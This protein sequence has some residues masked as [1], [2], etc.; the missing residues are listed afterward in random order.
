MIDP[1]RKA[2]RIREALF[3]RGRIGVLGC[4]IARLD[5]LAGGLRAILRKRLDLAHVEAALHDL[6][7]DPFR[8]R[9]PDQHAGMAGGNLALRNVSLHGLRQLEQPQRV[10]H[11]AAALAYD[12]GDGVLAMVE[13]CCKRLIAHRLFERIEIGALHILDDRELQ[14]LAIVHIEL[15][16]RHHM[17]AGA[18]RRP[19][20]PL[21]GDD[22]VG[23][24]GAA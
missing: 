8:I 22:L 1:H 9:L 23:I 21:A 17:Q 16:D 10:G 5:R 20:A 13:L 4:A 24:G 12:L 18:L 3:E 15:H 11:V 14:R 7:R 19:P 6:T 2:E